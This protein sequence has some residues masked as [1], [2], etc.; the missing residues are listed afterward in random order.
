MDPNE[1]LRRIEALE[2]AEH[3][4][5]GRGY[6]P[7]EQKELTGLLAKWIDLGA[8]PPRWEECPNATRFYRIYRESREWTRR[9]LAE[10][11]AKREAERN[12][13]VARA[14]AP[15]LEPPPWFDAYGT[16]VKPPTQADF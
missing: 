10:L 2:V 5:Y 16:Y 8:P 14:L 7:P 9:Y 11:D 12:E 13:A 4:Y 1:I 3:P 6:I 15:P